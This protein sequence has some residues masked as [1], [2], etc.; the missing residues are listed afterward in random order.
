[1]KKRTFMIWMLAGRLMAGCLA[2][3]A[4]TAAQTATS[5]VTRV[6]QPSPGEAGD[7]AFD[8]LRTKIL[9]GG[10][11]AGEQD[12]LLLLRMGER[13][14]MPV[15]ASIT[16]RNYLMTHVRRSSELV[17]LAAENAVLCGDLKMAVGR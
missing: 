12:M 13:L 3:A 1:M 15:E 9:Q 17:R 2:W 7:K 6:A 4:V 5:A 14:G 16:L 10:S 8:E 11:T